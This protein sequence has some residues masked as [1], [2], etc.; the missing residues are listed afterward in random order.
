MQQATTDTPSPVLVTG[1]TGTLGRQV[2][3]RLREAGRPVRVIARSP[4]DGVLPDDVAFVRGDLS[5]GDGLDAALAG[6][7]VVVHCAGSPKGD[8][9]M[10]RN[11]VRAAARA[12]VRHL[13]FISVVGADRVPMAGRVDRM[14]F[15][16]FGSKRSA[17]LAIEDSGI[18]WTTLRATQ[19]FD[20]TL[21]TAEAMA[22]LPVVPVPSGLRF[23]PVDSGEVADRLTELALGEP[24]GL[25]GDFGGPADY[26]LADLVRSYLAAA[27]RS[28]RIVG[29]RVP[30]RAA[31]AIRAGATLAPDARLGRRTWEEFLAATVAPSAGE[32]A[33][34]AGVHDGAGTRP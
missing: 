13:V 26:E 27:G 29:V 2:V 17:E 30:G 9:A 14:A 5:T 28:R 31:A 33:G 18:P 25:A 32:P 7:D 11:L 22:K 10:T 24:R 15:G 1:G 21:R 6:V 23:Q 12:G 3:R 20:L 8:A 34:R 4:R 16:Y 19:F